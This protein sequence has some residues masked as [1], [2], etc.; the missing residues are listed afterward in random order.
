[1]NEVTADRSD[2]QELIR[3][4]IDDELD[5]AE[6]EALLERAA[7][8]EQLDAA[9]R[10]ARRTATLLAELPEPPEP[11][12]ELTRRIMAEVDREPAVGR[13]TSSARRRWWQLFARPV[14]VPAWALA[15]AVVAVGGLAWWSIV[16]R[17]A[18]EAALA[19]RSAR[20]PEPATATL[21]HQR[22]PTADSPGTK[23]PGAL[24][25]CTVQSDSVPVRF[26]LQA[27]DARS[28][29]VVGDF[30]DWSADR[31][32]LSDADKDGL[33][34]ITLRLT[35]G[36]YQYKFLVDGKRWVADPLAESY[37]VDG[38]GSRNAVISL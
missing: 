33:W 37:Q 21:A 4:Y 11:S 17:D 34:T 38:F 31:D 15:L 6:R 2:Q 13:S 16:A 28:V 25:T 14:A 26:V 8:D 9:L 24:S 20:R 23:P 18:R 12:A 1:M 10:R 22:P 30:N 27:P 3:R 29:A 19:A 36:R 5:A 35:R 7:A 32:L